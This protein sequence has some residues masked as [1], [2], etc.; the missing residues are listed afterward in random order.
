VTVDPD[1]TVAADGVM[2]TATSA[3]GEPLPPTSTCWGLV[4]A[5]SLMLRVALREP[6]AVG[7]K[8]MSIVQVA[9]GARL[10]GT[11]GQLPPI[12]SKSEGSAPPMEYPVTF[13]VM[14]PVL[15]IL[16]AF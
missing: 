5:L 2:N 8:Y 13:R 1:R 10:K 15:L 4:P 6:A 9:P 12:R 7:A 14:V 3:D 16:T 11:A